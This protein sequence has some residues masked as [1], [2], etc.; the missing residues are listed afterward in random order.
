MYDFSIITP[1]FNGKK[2]IKE[3]VSSVLKF[4]KNFSAEYI[5]VNDGSTD[6]TLDILKQFNSEIKVVSQPNSGESVAVNNGIK[7]AKG[8]WILIVNADDPLITSEL[9]SQAK[10]VFS[11]ESSVC[12]VYPDWQIIDETGK[13]LKKVVV[14]DYSFHTLFAEFHCLPGPGA[15]FRR[16]L[17]I[18]IGGRSSDYKFVSDYDFWLRMSQKGSFMHIPITGALWRE[19][20]DSTSVRLKGLA[21]GKERIEVIRNFMRMYPQHKKLER[22]AISHAY[23][24][25]AILGFFSNE[26]PARKWMIKALVLARGKISKSKFRIVIFVLL[27]PLSRQA[28]KLFQHLGFFQGKVSK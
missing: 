10:V 16:D 15:I 24:N 18:A 21:M 20:S 1:V 25:A 28:F 27:L 8:Q 19:H 6:T 3:T 23:Y 12:V 26:I 17:A 13:T 5:V 2:Y 9:F 7:I 11:K 22:Q 4:T 14:P